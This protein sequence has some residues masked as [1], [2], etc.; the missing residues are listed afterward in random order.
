M[1]KPVPSIESPYT[2]LFISG[3][4][5]SGST[6]VSSILG[7]HSNTVE[8]GE[9][10]N[11]WTRGVQLD[12]RCGCGHP[13]S[14]C[15][16]WQEVGSRAFGGWEEVDAERVVGYGKEL[17]RHRHGWLTVARIAFRRSVSSQAAEWATHHARVYDAIRA[18]SGCSVIV[19]SSKEP[20]YAAAIVHSGAIDLR[21]LHLVRDPRAVAF[22]FTRKK[23]R[24]EASGRGSSQ[25]AVQLMPRLGAVRASIAWTLRNLQSQALQLF[26]PYVRQ[27]YEAWSIDQIEDREREVQDELQL[28]L[29]G[30]HK[31]DETGSRLHL[32]GSHSVSGNPSR[33][34]R[35]HLV[36]IRP[37]T[38]WADAPRTWA[39]AAVSLL[40]F[41]LRLTYGYSRANSGR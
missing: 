33:F 31:R 26:V 4:G 10:R 5:R 9:L 3:E 24:H 37:D 6:I 13:F 21:V 22:S 30:S 2:V 16:F 20:A 29:S 17:A 1:A 27:R 18:V 11:I 39:R 8:V 25:G 32:S 28:S 12:E 40:T 14:R 35:T 41:P 7:D 34:E 15:E 36:E 23:I 38:A 19:D